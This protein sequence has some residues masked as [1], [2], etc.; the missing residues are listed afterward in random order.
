[1]TPAELAKHYL[2]FFVGATPAENAPVALLRFMKS[3]GDPYRVCYMLGCIAAEVVPQGIPE[4][5]ALRWI[6]EHP[7]AVEYANE[8]LNS[9]KGKK[10]ATPFM[11]AI[12]HAYDIECLAFYDKVLK[13]LQAEVTK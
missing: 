7:T 10:S 3:T 4:L 11:D 2:R 8:Y 6:Y 9:K 12:A 5:E 1:M 13:F